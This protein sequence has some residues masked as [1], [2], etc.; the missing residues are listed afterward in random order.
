MFAPMKLKTYLTENGMTKTA[1][2]R[3]TGISKPYLTELCQGK[4]WP[5]RRI[6]EVIRDATAGAVTANDFLE[7]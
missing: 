1:F 4:H 7:D 5:Q 6:V 2:S 3:L